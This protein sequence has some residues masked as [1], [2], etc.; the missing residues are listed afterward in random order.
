MKTVKILFLLVLIPLN[1]L[2]HT[3][4]ANILDDNCSVRFFRDGRKVWTERKSVRIMGKR[5]IKDFGEVVIPFFSSHQ[6]VKILYA[7]TVLPNG[8][9]IFPSKRAFNIVYPPFSSG[10][11]IYSDLKYKTISMPAVKKG[12]IVSYAF[13]VITFKPF[14]RKEFWTENVFQCNYPVK[15]AVFKAYV[16]KDI[17][18]KYKF[19]NGSD[20][21]TVVMLNNLKVLTWNLRNLPPID[22][23]TSMPSIES[24]SKRVIVTSLK[25]WN[26]VAS[27]YSGLSRSAI[28]PDRMI[29]DIT[30]KVIEGRKDKVRAIYDFV[31]Q[32]I[33]YVGMEFGING[34]KPHKA[35]VV[36]KNRY[37][38]CKDHATLL[39]SMLR[40]AGIE[41]YPVLVPTSDI[42]NMDPDMP[43]PMAFDHEIAAI[44]YNGKFRFLDT[45]SDVTPF[46]YIPAMDQG[47]N[48]LV[49]NVDKGT[50]YIR[51]TPILSANKN[52]ENFEGNFTLLDNG[53]LKGRFSYIYKGVYS[54][55][56]RYRLMSSSESEI[57][58]I[59]DSFASKLS[60][61][62]NIKVFKL[63][64]YKDIDVPYVTITIEGIDTNF[65]TK[66]KHIMLLRPP[67]PDYSRLVSLVASKQRRYP[68]VVGYRMMKNTSINIKIPK[69]YTIYLMPENFCYKNRIGTF[70]LNWSASKDK[71]NFTDRLVLNT[72]RIPAT[73]YPYL[74]KLFNVTVKTIR[75]QILVL[76][77]DK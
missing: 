66:T 41:A 42:A 22:D 29:K 57:K 43:Y 15:H 20:K 24:L 38:D 35:S 18:V 4:A 16:P 60:P 75:N 1:V 76:R 6:R 19:Y 26:D 58:S 53:S 74:R 73:E 52:Q 55:I 39:V 5:G 40:A 48:V 54:D 49:V 34:F 12:S 10:A 63:S 56:E 45:T 68:Y 23:E 64:N 17:G 36:L 44:K 21:P 2:A 46:G 33:R 37:G 28:R 71:V 32:N 62:F 13:K 72:Q 27:W 77:K 70:M 50:G 8:V 59:I 51:K 61:G 30:K 65:A 69:G 67:V 31:S 7:Y 47:R 3:Y 9:K 25:S 14:I 11:P